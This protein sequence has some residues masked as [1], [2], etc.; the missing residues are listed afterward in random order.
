M[1]ELALIIDFGSQYTQLI[2]RRVREMQVYCEIVPAD[3]TADQIAAKNPR[4]IILS[5]GPESVFSPHAPQLDEN[6]WKLNLPTLGICYGLQLLTQHFGGKVEPGKLREYGAARV[7]R[8]QEHALLENTADNSQV[9]MSHGDHVAVPPPEFQVILRSKNDLI[10]AIAHQEMPVMGL[11]FHPEVSHTE[12]GQTYLNN[13]LFKIAGFSGDWT[14]AHFIEQTIES[15]RKTVGSARVLLGLSGGVDSSVLAF[16]LH[17]AIGDQLLP[18]FI[19]N[20]LL[21]LHEARQVLD[22]FEHS[23]VKIKYHDYSDEFLAALKGVTDPEQKRKIIGRV[24]IEAFESAAKK[25]GAAEFLAQ[26]TLYPDVIESGSVIGKSHTIKSHH[27]VGGLPER[28]DMTV[29]EPFRELFKDE[30]RAVGRALG[31]PEHIIGRHPFPGPGLAVRCL[32]EITPEKLEVI[33]QSDHVF[34]QTLREYGWY[35]KV[36]QAFTVLLPV[37]TV[38]V[39][40]DQRTFENVV[41]LRSV[42]SMDGM[43]ANWSRIPAE[44]LAEAAEKIVNHVVGVNRV[45]YDITSK[46]PATI[47]WE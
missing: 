43:T 3:L 24:F 8:A 15:V 46:P 31:V 28:L 16:L 11:Q 29:L 1:S 10:S 12:E 35:D 25:H 13:F 47:E 7:Q 45:V 9:W 27:N 41:A 5:G 17:E 42:D 20:G 32:G 37:Q 19:D 23:N 14:P 36:W 18:I 22:Q 33:R 26:G 40:G 34:I 38:G 39:M 4:A 21:R 2:A 44:L 30:V 6:V